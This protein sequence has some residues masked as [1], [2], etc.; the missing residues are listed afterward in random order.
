MD[1][2]TMSPQ[3]KSKTKQMKENRKRK[4]IGENVR[5]C[6]AINNKID[7]FLVSWLCFASKITRP[8]CVRKRMQRCTVRALQIRWTQNTSLLVPT[9][10]LYTLSEPLR[11]YF[12][13][14]SGMCARYDQPLCHILMCF[15]LSFASDF[16]LFSFIRFHMFSLVRCLHFILC[17]LHAASA[18][19]SIFFIL[20]AFK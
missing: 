15:L 19:A 16:L 12:V 1:R 18:L 3:E 6:Y 9:D 20:F 14:W 11:F 13:L 10:S 8:K 17:V 4:E 7:L 2:M 5:R